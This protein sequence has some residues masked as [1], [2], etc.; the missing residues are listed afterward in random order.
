MHSSPR[1]PIIDNPRFNPL[2]L[3]VT[4]TLIAFLY[5]FME[6]LFII[7]KPSFLQQAAF[8][9]KVLVF[10]T[11]AALLTAICLLFLLPF[12]ILHAFAKSAKFTILLRLITVFAPTLVLTSLALMMIDN[13]TYTVF[14]FGIVS[15]GGGFRILYAALFIFLGV[16]FLLR[17]SDSPTWC[18]KSF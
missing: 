18:R 10:F 9:D 13:F 8:L 12:F 17:S 6:W 16:F 11:T 2:S 15:A 7:T 1:K 3:V 4:T 5:I 14:N